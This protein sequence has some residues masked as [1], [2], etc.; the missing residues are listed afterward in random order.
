M[1]PEPFL[2]LAVGSQGC[3]AGGS[4][5]S[6]APDTVA[7]SI[8]MADAAAGASCLFQKMWRVELPSWLGTC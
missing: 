6:V 8:R 5:C 3:R 2:G 1:A 7:A 4:C